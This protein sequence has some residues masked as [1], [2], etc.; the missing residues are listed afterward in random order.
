[1][2]T[3]RPQAVI[4]DLDGLIIDTEVVARSAWQQSAAELGYQMNDDLYSNFIGRRTDDCT[5]KLLE[6][7]GG[8]FPLSDFLILSDRLCRE[9]LDRHGVPFKPGLHELLDL[10]DSRDMTKAVAT[11]SPREDALLNL[12]ALASRFTLIVGGDEL[13]RGKPAPEIYLLTAARLRLAPRQCLALEDAALGVQAAYAAGMPV[14][15]VPDLYRPSSR[16]ASMATGICS[17]LY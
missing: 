5:A 2:L 8:A 13:T 9:Y 11:G 3:Y 6:A 10:L 14:I 16:I 7:Y 17:S 1:M 12:G 15:M 4:F